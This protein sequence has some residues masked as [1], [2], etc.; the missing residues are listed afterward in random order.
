M[1]SGLRRLVGS[2]KVEEKGDFV[3]I[4]GLPADF[5]NDA[6]QRIWAT[7]KI[8]QYMFHRLSSSYLVFYKFFLPD[9]LYTLQVVAEDRRAKVNARAIGKIVEGIY[10]NTWAK[11]IVQDFNER[12]DYS[13]LKALHKTPLPE[14]MEFFQM[15]DQNTQKYQLKGFLLGARPGSGKTYMSIALNAM[16]H[17]DIEF[18]CVPQ[19]S[20]DRVW[21]ASLN[22]G[23]ISDNKKTWTSLSN[24]PLE[25]GYDRYVFHYEQLERLLAFVTANKRNLIGK[26]NTVTLDESHNF[27]DLK[28]QR[29]GFFSDFCEALEP[30]NVLW[31]SGTA[32]KAIGNEAVPLLRT[33]DPFF[34]ARVEERFIKIFGKNSSRANDILRNRLGFVMYKTDKTNA[35]INKV[36]TYEGN[37]TIPNGN[38]YTLESIKKEMKEFV[39]ERSR[40]Y[41]ANQQKYIQ[42]YQEGLRYYA[43]TI[44]SSAQRQEFEQY[45]RY[46]DMIRKGYDPV[47]MKAEALFCNNF[48]AKAIL[49]AQP[50]SEL[51][52]RF[53]NAKSVYKYVDLKILGEALGRVLGRRRTECN[54]EMVQGL[55]SFTRKLKGTQTEERLSISDFIDGAKK[56]TIIFTS[57][58]PVVDALEKFLIAEGYKPLKV[59]GLTNKDLP[60]I[61]NE[62]GLNDDLNPLIAT[63]QSL[64]S[65]VPMVMANNSLMMNTPF[66][67]Y[68]MEQA[69]ARTDRIGQ[70]ED[71]Y[72]TTVL[73]DTKGEPN[74]STRSNEIM[75]WSRQQVEEILGI[76]TA[77]NISLESL[78]YSLDDPEFSNEFHYI[79]AQGPMD[80]STVE[81]ETV[82]T[83]P[84]PVIRR[85]PL[86]W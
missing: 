5:L 82:K 85:E 84:V 50:T 45:K 1:L 26:R 29:V 32:I 31:M 58:V 34:H 18:Y 69:I 46:A 28:S 66:R 78:E 15:F 11:T 62:F 55:R 39:G 10:E 12:L 63:Y 71:V 42:E 59:Y 44:V 80:A 27:N 75:E 65:A 49:P 77:P 86:K 23:E 37:I 43:A 51:R 36:L 24:K 81:P 64:S 33:I 70:T 4:S 19:N 54:V 74:I 41:K 83:T 21:D 53:K 56:K 7:S 3:T 61:V 79:T 76:K 52:E 16:L 20:V 57:F 8:G 6:I 47:K 2:I 38:L 14:Q 40:Y 13:A 25:M 72:V 73:L 67:S 17:A 22:G 35:T 68:E 60:Q 9:V 30:I 48:E